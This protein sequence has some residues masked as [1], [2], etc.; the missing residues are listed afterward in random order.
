VARLR[1]PPE[2]AA[3][4]GIQWGTRKKLEPPWKSRKVALDAQDDAALVQQV[5]RGQQAAVR[6]TDARY[7]R[8]FIAPRARS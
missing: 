5:Q 3:S 1:R 8:A 4:C 7:N 6:R 2:R